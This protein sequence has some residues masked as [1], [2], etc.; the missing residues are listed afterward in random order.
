LVWAAAVENLDGLKVA[1][2]RLID[3]TFEENRLRLFNRLP[4]NVATREQI[5]KT[6]EMLRDKKQ[7]DIIVTDWINFFR[8]KYQHVAE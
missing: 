4:E 6:A 1:K 2:K 7:L 8:E 5:S 3:T